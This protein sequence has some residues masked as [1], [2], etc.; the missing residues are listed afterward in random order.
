MFILEAIN[1]QEKKLSLDDKQGWPCKWN[2]YF[3]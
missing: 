2:S 1:D 3:K